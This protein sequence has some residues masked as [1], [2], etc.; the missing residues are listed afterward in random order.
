MSSKSP[1]SKL[2]VLAKSASF[3]LAAC[4]ILVPFEANGSSLKEGLFGYAPGISKLSGLFGYPPGI[5]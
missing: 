2:L 5:S 3:V 1:L 4:L